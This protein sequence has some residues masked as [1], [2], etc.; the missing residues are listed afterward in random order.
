MER[1]YFKHLKSRMNLR[2]DVENLYSGY[3]QLLNQKIYEKYAPELNLKLHQRTV[4]VERI[5]L[6]V[7]Y[8]GVVF[9]QGDDIADLSLRN[10][11]RILSHFDMKGCKPY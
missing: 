4:L 10:D 3:L 7:N 9:G 5:S 8:Y 2:D 11:E 6:M 1:R